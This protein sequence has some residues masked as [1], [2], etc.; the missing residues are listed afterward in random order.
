MQLEQGNVV[1]EGL[2]VVVVV[3]VGGG[4]PECLRPRGPVLLREV[5]VPDTHVDR[6]TRPNNAETENMN[7]YHI[8]DHLCYGV[9]RT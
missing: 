3:D 8:M 2:A 9:Q 7:S 1:V 4:H 6:V 5:M